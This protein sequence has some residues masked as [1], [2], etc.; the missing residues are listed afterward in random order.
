MATD[1]INGVMRRAVALL[2][3]CA[4]LLAPVIISMTHG[5]GDAANAIQAA[6]VKAAHGHTHEWDEP[7]KPGQ[8]DATDHEHNVAVV[9]T[10]GAQSIFDL[11]SAAFTTDLGVFA[12]LAG[13]G[14][15]RPP[16][17]SIV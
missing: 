1:W 7:G 17:D 14:L 11:K 13:N 8:H 9:L 3:F 16:R 12:G 15:R 4:L 6:A 2:L 5:P 10:G